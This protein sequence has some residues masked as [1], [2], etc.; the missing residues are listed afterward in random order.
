M[1][2]THLSSLSLTEELA[3]RCTRATR[4]TLQCERFHRRI[5]FHKGCDGVAEPLIKVCVPQTIEQWEGMHGTSRR[6]AAY[7]KLLKRI[8]CMPLLSASVLKTS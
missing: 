8:T 4:D 5:R 6:Q 1:T 3:Q 2:T 7:N